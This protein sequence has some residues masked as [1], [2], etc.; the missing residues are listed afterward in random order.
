MDSIVDSDPRR[1]GQQNGPE[2]A[3]NF[4]AWPQHQ[5]VQVQPPAQGWQQVQYITAPI[6]NNGHDNTPSYYT[7]AQNTANW[8][9]EVEMAAASTDPLG[10]ARD[11]EMTTNTQSSTTVPTAPTVT[12]VVP[13]T[14]MAY[15]TQP[16]V[17]TS[18]PTTN[19][20][21]TVNSTPTAVSATNNAVMPPPGMTAYRKKPLDDVTNTPKRV[22]RGSSGNV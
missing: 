5:V 11:V 12:T 4:H 2:E 1:Q 19:E 17:T 21:Q 7:Y 18:T 8:A 22:Q 20:T 6:T 13:T 3:Q 10:L 15:S 16:S 9:Q 14:V